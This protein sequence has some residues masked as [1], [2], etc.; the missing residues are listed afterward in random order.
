MAFDTG[1]AAQQ[2]HSL[3]S[4]ILLCVLHFQQNTRVIQ[5][6]TYIEGGVQFILTRFVCCVLIKYSFILM[7]SD[8]NLVNVLRGRAPCSRRFGLGDCFAME[9]ILRARLCMDLDGGEKQDYLLGDTGGGARRG[10]AG[11]R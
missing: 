5:V 2:W 9:I 7:S 3:R 10:S 11:K 8:V 6:M 4:L 1:T